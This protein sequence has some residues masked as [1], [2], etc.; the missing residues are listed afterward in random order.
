MKVRMRNADLRLKYLPLRTTDDDITFIFEK[1]RFF[2]GLSGF[3][4]STYEAGTGTNPSDDH[5]SAIL[6]VARR[7]KFICSSSD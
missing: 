2:F 5:I 4:H 1:N 6:K 7:L 3:S